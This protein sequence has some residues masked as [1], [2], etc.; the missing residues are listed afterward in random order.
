MDA[1]DVSRGVEKIPI[2]LASPEDLAD[3][4]DF[5]VRQ[6]IYGVFIN[7]SEYLGHMM[8]HFVGICPEVRAR[9][10]IQKEGELSCTGICRVPTQVYQGC[11]ISVKISGK[12]IV[13]SRP[14]KCQGIL[15]FVREKGNFGEYQGKLTCVR[16]KL[17]FQ[18]YA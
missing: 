9:R 18:V 7:L 3:A 13:F 8:G 11:H 10:I 5:V 2:P 12:S 15:K 6:G 17:N 14:G 4:S 1:T 16:E